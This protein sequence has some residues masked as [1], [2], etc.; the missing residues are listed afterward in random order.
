MLGQ[1]D[2]AAGD[3]AN[4]PPRIDYHSGNKAITPKVIGGV[5]RLQ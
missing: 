2:A 3:F 5:L 1:Q 4:H